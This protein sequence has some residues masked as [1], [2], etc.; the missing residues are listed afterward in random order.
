MRRFFAFF[1][2]FALIFAAP[3][4]AQAKVR[5]A[6]D[7]S[8]QRM[9]VVSDSGASYTWPISTARSGYV[10]PHGTY[11]PTS[12]QVM[13][14]SKKYH[15]SPMPHSIFFHGGYAIHG[16][17]DVGALGR[18]ASHGCVRVSPANAATLYQL[19]HAE[20]AVI[21]I[22]GTP[23]AS[24]PFAAEGGHH[25]HRRA[26]NMPQGGHEGGQE[27]LSVFGGIFN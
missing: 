19:V 1:A 12:L 26:A 8:N 9:D 20:G 24:R 3:V 27:R 23:P 2:I 17:Y 25:R 10:T 18:P 14:R 16:T 4:A 15:N 5:I 7:L 21:T 13:H 22:D 11:A 6:V